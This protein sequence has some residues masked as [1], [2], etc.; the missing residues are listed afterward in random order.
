MY[1][2]QS[3]T[4]PD[5]QF[6]RKSK[7]IAALSVYKNKLQRPLLLVRSLFVVYVDGFYGD[8]VDNFGRTLHDIE[9][10]WCSVDIICIEGP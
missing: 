10:D 5:S 7:F 6:G 1:P 2:F 3:T 9:H 4:Q 8:C